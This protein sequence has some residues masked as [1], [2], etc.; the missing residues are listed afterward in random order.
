MSVQESRTQLPEPGQKLVRRALQFGRVLRANGVKVTPGQVMD[1]VHATQHV[2]IENRRRFKEA[3]EATL[4]TR[5]EDL[6]V[7]DVIFDVLLAFQ[8]S[9]RR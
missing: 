5:K 6:A 1:F 2:G 4:V 9:A 3:G 7:F 8:A